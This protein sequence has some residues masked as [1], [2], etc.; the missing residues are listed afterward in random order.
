MKHVM[1]AC[2]QEI[3]ADSGDLNEIKI[4]PLGDINSEQG[5]FNVDEESVRLMKEEFE[6]R[7]IDIVVDYEHQTLKDIAAPAGGWIKDFYIKD[8]AVTADIQWTG[9]GKEYVKNKEYRYLS[10]VVV[11][12][13]SDNKAVKLHSVALTNTP[14]IN[15]MFSITNAEDIQKIIK[16]YEG[17]S[18]MDL[19]QNL[20]KVLNLNEGS[21]EESI[22]NKVKEL[23]DMQ[24]DKQ[25]EENEEKKEEKKEEK[26]E[27]T[28]ANKDVLKLLGLNESAGLDEVT[29]KIML[30]KKPAGVSAEE[31]NKLKL[32]MER[33][34]AEE[35]VLLAMKE[36]KITPVQKE[37]AE[38]YALKSPEGFKAF[39]DKA[40]I[41]VP[42]GEF[43]YVSNK[44]GIGKREPGAAELK[45]GRMLGVSKDYIEKYGKDD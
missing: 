1:A 38:E 17:G 41:V 42:V 28:V 30:L 2:S 29:E 4:M 37:W 45:I 16:K 18:E 31:F 3:N 7:G 9:K 10:P 13:K 40:P 15:G 20:I 5:F 8:N 44:S 27:Q 14:A 12:R 32:K 36:G 21:D 35:S 26:E 22:I 11:V 34:E 33:K 19:L 24:A 6:R 23:L 43:E 39:I 25:K